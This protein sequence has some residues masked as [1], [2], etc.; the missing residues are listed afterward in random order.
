MHINLD[1]KQNRDVHL[2][3]R[4]DMNSLLVLDVYQHANLF[5][6]Q[7]LVQEIADAYEAAYINEH[8]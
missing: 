1:L 7:V 2:R 8:Y 5:L 3:Q 4:Y 6:A